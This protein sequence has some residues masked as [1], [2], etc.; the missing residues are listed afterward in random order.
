MCCVQGEI[1]IKCIKCGSDDVVAFV[2]QEGQ[3][4]DSGEG[5]PDSYVAV[6]RKHYKEYTSY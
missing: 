3:E 4:H 2:K 6:C 1:M 5:Y